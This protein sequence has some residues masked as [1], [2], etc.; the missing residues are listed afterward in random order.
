MSPEDVANSINNSFLDSQ[1]V[2][3]PLDE[4]AKIQAQTN[5]TSEIFN[6]TTSS[7]QVN[8]LDTYKRLKSPN[9]DKSSGPDGISPWVYKAYAE[10]LAYPVSV[11]LNC[12]YNQGKLLSLW[13]SANISPIPKETQITDINKHLRPISLTPILSKVA[14]E[15]IL[16]RHLKF[17][18]LKILDPKQF[19][20]VA[21][22]STTVALVSMLHQWLQAADQTGNLVRIVLF[23]FQ[24]AFIMLDHNQLILKFKSLGLSRQIANCIIDFLINRKQR[25]KLNN[26]CFSDWS[27]VLSGVPQGTKLGTWLY[28]LM[29]NDLTTPTTTSCESLWKYVDDTTLSETISKKDQNR[30]QESVDAVQVWAISNMAEL[31]QEKCKELRIDLSR[32][33]TESTC[34]HPIFIN[35]KEIE[36][37]SYAK[38]LGLTVSNDFN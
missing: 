35:H 9:P 21:R 6:L 16:E 25:V 7:L 4:S 37:V 5:N 13:K 27:N 22:S 8:E 12:S 23:D 14:E 30:I 28:I 31:N 19:G 18:I 34:L 32:E 15:F 33:Q 20:V 38:T 11:I 17:A 36:V 10:I 24:K 26:G 2:Y 1:Q 29:I 3:T